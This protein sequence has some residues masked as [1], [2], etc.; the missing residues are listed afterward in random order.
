[1][2]DFLGVA[3]IVVL[4]FNPDQFAAGLSACIFCARALAAKGYR[5]N[6]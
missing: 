4:V 6:P 2:V 1:L 5:F 3:A